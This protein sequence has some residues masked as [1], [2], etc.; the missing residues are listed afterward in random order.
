MY[1]SVSESHCIV[2]ARGSQNGIH[3]EQP[4]TSG[5]GEAQDNRPLRRMFGNRKLQFWSRDDKRKGSTKEAGTSEA[6]EENTFNQ[7]AKSKARQVFGNLKQ[8]VINLLICFQEGK[9]W[10]QIDFGKDA[11]GWSAVLHSLSTIFP[12]AVIIKLS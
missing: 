9:A 4:G 5:R 3:E 8:A 11:P 7:Q 10:Q 6:A 2:A 1:E 12:E